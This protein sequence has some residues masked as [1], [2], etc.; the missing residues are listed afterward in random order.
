[1]ESGSGYGESYALQ[2]QAI[3][4]DMSAMRIMCLVGTSH[5]PQA[6][7]KYIYNTEGKEAA[8]FV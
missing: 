7:Y 5:Q 8:P 6:T 2:L 1:V 3:G 4:I